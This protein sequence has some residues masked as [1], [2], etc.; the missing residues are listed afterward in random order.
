VQL[1]KVAEFKRLFGELETG[2]F[3]VAQ[4]LQ[5]ALHLDKKIN[6]RA[7]TEIFK[8]GRRGT[9]QRGEVVRYEATVN[10]SALIGIA[11]TPPRLAKAMLVESRPGNQS[12]KKDFQI[13]GDSGSLAFTSEGKLAGLFFMSTQDAIRGAYSNGHFIPVGEL[14]ADIEEVTG[15]KVRMDT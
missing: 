8:I 1:P 14:L 10:L 15:A 9:I 7:G 5:P 13:P 2:F 4:L 12:D 6:V 3:D 11:E